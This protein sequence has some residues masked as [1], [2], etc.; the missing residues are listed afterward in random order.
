M[1]SLFKRPLFIAG[2]ILILIIAGG[3]F[4]LVGEEDVKYEIAIA[5]RK[6]LIQEVNITG[7]VVAAQHVD[8]AFEKSGRVAWV[9]AG[10]SDTVYVGE[11]LIQL[12][13]ANEKAQLDQAQASLKIQQAN[14][15]ELLRGSRDEEIEI[16]KIK[17]ANAKLSLKEAKQN[18]VDVIADAF[19]KSDDAVRNKV[20]QFITNPRTFN[21]NVDFTIIDF[22]L[23]NDIEQGRIGI[24]SILNSWQ[25]SI[26][27]LSVDIVLD[28]YINTTKSN[29]GQ[30]KSFLDWL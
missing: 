25:T 9:G 14:L 6:D 3:L 29:L 24:E 18:L 16:Q 5:E 28:S 17:V 1:T 12:E 2:A 23:E 20:D 7:R 10:V 11:T 8:L 13:N 22:Q 4:F 19:T 26:A 21:P 27:S 15:N 30:V